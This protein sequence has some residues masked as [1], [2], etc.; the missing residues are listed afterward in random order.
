MKNI[1]V[2]SCFL[3]AL[4][5][6][7]DNNNKLSISIYENIFERNSENILII[8]W[9]ILYETIS[10]RMVRQKKRI[11]SINTHWKTLKTKNRLELINDSEY[12]KDALDS[13]FNETSRGGNYRA[14][15]LTDRVIRI[16]LED[17]KID[18]FVS[19]NEGDFSDVCKRKKIQLIS[20][21]DC[22]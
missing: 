8:P 3:I 15:S 9:P 18:G 10:T 14:L 16:I 12:R 2:D 20:N 21:L 11:E 1:C 13:C 19:F 7:K 22:L 17:K 5:D 6:N 4:Y